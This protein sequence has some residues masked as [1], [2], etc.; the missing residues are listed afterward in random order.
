MVVESGGEQREPAH[1]IK[2][3]TEYSC[4]A[5]AAWI[6]FIEKARPAD[7]FLVKRMSHILLGEDAWFRRIE[8]GTVDPDVWSV[9]TFAQMRERLAK[10]RDV[11]QS[12]LRHD[13]SHVVDYTRFSGEKYR[14]PISDILVHLSHHGAHH[15]GQMATYISAQ[16]TAPIN[17]DFIQFCLVNRL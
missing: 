9:L 10:H 13:L 17:T 15:R 11:Y 8:G 6:D 5:N 2:R 7:D 4:W 12:L 3:L 16:G 1:G 14:S